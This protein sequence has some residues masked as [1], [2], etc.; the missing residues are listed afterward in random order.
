MGAEK[1]MSKLGM[2][3]VTAI[4]HLAVAILRYRR[5]VVTHAWRVGN[6]VSRRFAQQPRRQFSA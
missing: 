2:T 5:L 4:L 1:A 3:Q 6:R